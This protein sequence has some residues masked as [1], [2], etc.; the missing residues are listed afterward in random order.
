MEKFEV[1]GGSDSKKS[2]PVVEVGASMLR[3]AARVS[4]PFAVI[5]TVPVPVVELF[6]VP[7]MPDVNVKVLEALTDAVNPA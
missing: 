7:V 4:P 1:A 2:V 5:T 3:L 6:V